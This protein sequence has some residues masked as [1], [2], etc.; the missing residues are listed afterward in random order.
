M[1]ELLEVRDLQVTFDTPDGTVTAVDGPDQH[2][3]DLGFVGRVTGADA[4][5]I[6]EA[7]V[8][9]TIPVIAPLATGPDGETL[10][11]N[12]DSAAAVIAGDMRAEKFVL[13]TDVPGILIPGT[14]TGEPT[15]A[16][17][18]SEADVE[19]HVRD[20]HIS[21]GMVP[22]VKACSRA[23]DA[24]VRKAHIIDGRIPHA[25]LLEIFTQSGVGT[26]IIGGPAAPPR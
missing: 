19:Q 9:Q 6:L 12:A 1:T 11:C 5:T 2:G 23:L 22:K 18:L 10:N 13:L 17:T 26:E 3:E 8:S 4:D 20:G 15:L 7:T 16:S 14:V 21:G 24:G 25:L